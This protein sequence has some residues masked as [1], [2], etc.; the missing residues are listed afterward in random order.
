MPDV[1]I[2]KNKQANVNNLKGNHTE[3][4]AQYHNHECIKLL[5]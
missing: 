3:E 1:Y 4:T 5:I 2:K